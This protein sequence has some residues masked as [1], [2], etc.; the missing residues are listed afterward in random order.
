MMDVYTARSCDS[1]RLW[2]GHVQRLFETLE[3]QDPRAADEISQSLAAFCEQQP[4]VSQQALSLLTARSFCVTGDRPA[5]EQILK[6]DCTHRPHADSWLQVLSEE[7]PFPEL[8]P[9][10]NSRAMRPLRLLST[11]KRAAWA[12]D[13]RR[14][15]LPESARHEMIIFRTLRTLAERI[16]TV[17]KK[18]RGQGS[19]VVKS[20]PK[21]PICPAEL[22]AY[23]QDVLRDLSGKNGWS[24]VPSVLLFDL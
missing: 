22:T 16:S 4:C 9:L 23:L 2:A 10:F 19:L 21:L 18:Q 3:L 8:Y 1:R 13:L 6:Q 12:L 5:A 14:I 11:G 15:D 17:W 24:A 7:D 20:G